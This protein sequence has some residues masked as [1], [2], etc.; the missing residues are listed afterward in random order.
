MSFVVAIDGPAASGK[1]TVA[2]RIAAEFG[3]AYL[4]TGSLYRKTAFLVLEAGGSPADA[5]DAVHA[6]R[7]VMGRSVPDDALRTRE[8]A[9]AASKVAAIPEVR[10]A[11]VEVQRAFGTTPPAVR[12][13]LQRAR[14]W[15]GGT[16]ERSFSPIAR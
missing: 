9:E 15:T 10:A 1:G 7:E 14:S 3:F 13:R 4:D 6:A 5:E 16:S 11:L 2:K 12:E 8:V